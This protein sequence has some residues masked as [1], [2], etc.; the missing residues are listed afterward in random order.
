[1]PQLYQILQKKTI[2]P[3]LEC[4]L[5]GKLFSYQQN[6]YKKEKKKKSKQKLFNISSVLFFLYSF[7][8]IIIM[9][10]QEK[11]V[12]F[13]NIFKHVGMEQF[14][15]L[16]FIILLMYKSIFLKIYILFSF[17]FT[18]GGVFELENK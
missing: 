11:D 3:H 8:I 1:M 4:L 17:I 14:I 12:Y 2:V 7:S 6:A 10:E 5:L 18:L 16:L 15:Y 9:F 13:H